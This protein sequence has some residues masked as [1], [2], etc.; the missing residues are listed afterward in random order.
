VVLIELEE[1]RVEFD[2]GHR[3]SSH[4]EFLLAHIYPPPPWSPSPILL[5]GL[6]VLKL[7]VQND[8][9]LLKNLHK[10]FNKADLSWVHL[11]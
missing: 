5:G 9:L 8:V 7:R 10:F 3:L 2:L 11:I 6:G 4:R 1:R